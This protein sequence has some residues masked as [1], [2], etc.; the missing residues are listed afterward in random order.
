MLIAG[1]AHIPLPIPTGI[2]MA[3]YARRTGTARGFHDTLA[4]RAL[5]VSASVQQVCVLV[6]DTLCVDAHMTA[7][8]RSQ[9]SS[10]TGVAPDA[11]MV[12]ATHTHSGPGGTARF[13]IDMGAESYMGAYNPDLA[14]LVTQTFVTAAVTALDRQSAVRLEYGSGT[15]TGVGAN[16]VHDG[17]PYDPLIPYLRLI[18][19]NG[20]KSIYLLSYACHPTVLGPEN[21]LYSGD[22]TGMACAVLEQHG[23]RNCI[24]ISL[25]GAAGN[26]STR[27]TRVAPTFD[28]AERLARRLADAV[29]GAESRQDES[30]TVAAIRVPVTLALKPPGDRAAYEVRL[31]QVTERRKAAASLTSGERRLIESEIESLKAALDTSTA[32]PPALQTEVQVLRIGSTR[33]AAFP[34]ELYVEY[35]LAMREQFAPLP[36]MVAGYANDYIGYVPT[37]A[38][39]DSYETT[40]AVVAPDSGSRLVQAAR[41]AISQSDIH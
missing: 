41:R 5:I 17:G 28:E 2:A 26:I 30:D 25:T 19:L 33:I 6:A 10:A 37:S 23:S 15:V 27:F 12:A 16:R 4:V 14:A 21:L 34:G 1:A 38:A 24:A 9:V 11:I 8:V 32:R 22:L 29:I 39:P 31:A 3:G 36:V 20:N 13:P 7:D 35:G 40:M 18:D